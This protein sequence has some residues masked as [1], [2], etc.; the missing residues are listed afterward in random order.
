MFRRGRIRSSHRRE[1]VHEGET[2]MKRTLVLGLAVVG[3]ALTGCGSDDGGDTDGSIP[4]TTAEAAEED[5]GGSG[6]LTESQAAAAEMAIS[7][8]AEGGVDLDESCV[9]EIAA[10]LT[11]A[12][13]ASIAAEDGTQLSAEGEALGTELLRCAPEDALI[14]LFVSGL[15]EGGEEVDEACA[16]EQLEGVD[17]VDLVTATQT[18]GSPPIDVVEKLI[19]CFPSTSTP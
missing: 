2:L 5:G 3:L 11:E 6:D 7:D 8:A 4:A 17:I 19:E 9:N 15:A 13:A 12:D 1:T 14:D 16:R 10:Q 18:G